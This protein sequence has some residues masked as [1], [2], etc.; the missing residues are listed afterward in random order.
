MARVRL[1]I[2]CPVLEQGTFVELNKKQSH[3]ISHVMRHAAGESLEIFNG[4]DGLWLA[5]IQEES[6]KKMRILEVDEH[7]SP[8]ISLP[9]VHLCF[10]PLKQGPL[11]VLVEKGT[12]LGVTRFHP[13]VTERTVVR[14]F[15]EEKHR[16]TALE[17]CE[18]CERLQ[19]PSFAPLYSLDR[20]LSQLNSEEDILYVCDE[21]RERAGTILNVYDQG[22]AAYILIGPEGGF[23]PVEFEKLCRHKSVR[24]VSLNPHVLRA[25]T[26]AIVALSQLSLAREG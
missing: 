7:L 26:A 19:V 1:Y 5:H 11:H 2:D 20:F 16:L 9:T 10:A 21:R 8:Q 14:A 17:A 13:L 15:K 25:E 3:Y 12:E 24:F 6:S 23:S 4:R 22:R 18:Q